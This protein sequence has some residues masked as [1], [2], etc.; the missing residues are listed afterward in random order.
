MLAS[1]TASVWHLKS[2]SVA[3][4]RFGLAFY[5]AVEIDLLRARVCACVCVCVRVYA[6][7]YVCGCMCVLRQ[8]Q[9]F[10]VLQ[11]KPHTLTPWGK[12][13]GVK[14]MKLRTARLIYSSAWQCML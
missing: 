7:I 6:R 4:S 9:Y 10:K 11:Y 2:T 1:Q 14:F 12:G 13:V 3:V 8:I 5:T